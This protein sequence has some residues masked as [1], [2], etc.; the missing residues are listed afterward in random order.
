MKKLV[1]VL[2]MMLIC[3]SAFAGD[4]FGIWNQ[5]DI[6]KKVTSK[7]SVSAGEELRGR[8][9]DG[10]FYSDTHLGVSYKAYTNLK[11]GADY[12]FVEQYNTKSTD[13]I[14]ENRPRVYLT[15]SYTLKGYLLEDRNAFELRLKEFSENTFRYRNR[16][17]VTAP[18]KWTRYEI[19]PFTSEEVFIESN[20]NGLAE[21]Q[22]FAGLK[23]HIYKPIYGSV[24]Y[25]LQSTKNNYSDWQQNQVVGTGIKIS[26]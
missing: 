5:F 18:Y 1:F 15:P 22:I 19:Q 23:F 11:V 17:T 4:I 10:V 14:A 25:V 9:A 20:R 2:A 21:N 24:F 26:L 6:E 12:L 3:K 13:W 7:T 16:I 8:T